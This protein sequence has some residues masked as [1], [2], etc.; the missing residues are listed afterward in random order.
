MTL[1][2]GVAAIE[3][4]NLFWTS[5]LERHASFT[6]ARADAALFGEYRFTNTFGLNA[7]VRYSANIS[8]T[9]IPSQPPPPGS[10]LPP[11]GIF[12]MSWK[13]FEAYLGVRWFM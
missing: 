12:D 8:S 2:G 1:E 10:M 9:E 11:P 13:R 4:P 5:G 3:Y 6:D 7:T